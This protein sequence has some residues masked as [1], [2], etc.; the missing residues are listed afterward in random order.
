[1]AWTPPPLSDSEPSDDKTTGRRPPPPPPPSAPVN[2]PPPPPPPPPAADSWKPSPQSQ[3]ENDQIPVNA[4]DAIQPISARA[5]KA[6]IGV[7]AAVVV[8]LGG[9]WAFTCFQNRIP[10]G[11][12]KSLVESSLSK[13]GSKIT[14]VSIKVMEKTSTS[15]DAEFTAKAE[16]TEPRYVRVPMDE[17]LRQQGVDP[18]ISRKIDQILSLPNAKHILAKAHIKMGQV[19]GRERILIKESASIGLRYTYAGDIKASRQGKW[20]F[21]ING[22]PRSDDLPPGQRLDQYGTQTLRVD[23]P[24]NAEELKRLAGGATPE[25]LL[26]LQ[27]AAAAIDREQ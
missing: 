8:A 4:N 25:M 10:W 5:K 11:E 27:T 17:Y 13:T 16:L 3:P 7:A 14:D 9:F 21:A 6:W 15:G 22:I 26:I 1:M 19:N 24:E 20:A 18:D 12:A 23:N 2:P